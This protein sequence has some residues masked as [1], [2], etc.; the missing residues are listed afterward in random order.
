MRQDFPGRCIA[1]TEARH[2]CLLYCFLFPG[3]KQAQNLCHCL[4]IGALSVG[5]DA[6]LE[7]LKKDAQR[8]MQRKLGISQH[9]DS[10]QEPLHVPQQHAAAMNSPHSSGWQFLALTLG[11]ESD[12]V[13]C[14]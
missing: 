14:R 5:R 6:A 1:V 9:H 13:S 4:L 12:A 3:A 11:A 2:A 8:H 7:Q 10:A